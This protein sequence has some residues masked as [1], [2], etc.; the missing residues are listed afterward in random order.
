MASVLSRISGLIEFDIC[1][2]TKYLTIRLNTVHQ[3][4]DIRHAGLIEF[5]IRLK[6]EYLT[7]Y[8]VK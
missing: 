8:P 4:L 1:L 2:E 3:S 7:D 6:T 5:D